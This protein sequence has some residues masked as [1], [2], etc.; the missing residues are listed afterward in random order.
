MTVIAHLL[1]GV[2]GGVYIS[3]VPM[4]DYLHMRTV[5]AY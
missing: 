4:G 1:Y 2:L 3:I 5:K